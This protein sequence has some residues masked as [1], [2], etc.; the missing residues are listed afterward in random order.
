M[1]GA[2]VYTQG[3]GSYSQNIEIPVVSMRSPDAG[4][5][6]YPIGKRWINNITN[7]EYVLTSMTSFAPSQKAFWLLL[8][9]INFYVASVGTATL[10]GGAITVNDPTV[11]D[12]SVILI[13]QLNPVNTSDISVSISGPGTFTID[14]FSGTDASTV[15]YMVVN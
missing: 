1:T 4:D 2:V 6:D 13:S 15:S 12:T 7:Q 3:F 11:V 8:N 9:K 10:S 5:T 14:S